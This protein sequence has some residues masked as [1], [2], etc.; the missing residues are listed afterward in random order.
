MSHVHFEEIAR[1]HEQE[2]RLYIS[3][4]RGYIAYVTAVGENVEEAQKKAYGIIDK[5][6]IPKMMYRNDI[7][8]RFINKDRDLLKKWGY[9]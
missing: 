5:I 4:S 3:D 7:G 1:D 8:N 6:V 9:L 2:N